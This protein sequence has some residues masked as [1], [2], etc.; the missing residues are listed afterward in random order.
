[1]SSDVSPG[2]RAS[3]PA[4]KLYPFWAAHSKRGFRI[5]G[6]AIDAISGILLDYPGHGKR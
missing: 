1:M 3:V 2:M 4:Y 5:G 6:S